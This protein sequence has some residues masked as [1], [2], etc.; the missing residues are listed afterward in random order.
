MSTSEAIKVFEK[1][2]EGVLKDKS[3]FT[4]LRNLIFLSEAGLYTNKNL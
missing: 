4:Y 2:M 3:K 1:E